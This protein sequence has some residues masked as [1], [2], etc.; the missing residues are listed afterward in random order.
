ML[1][2]GKA[3][4]TMYIDCKDRRTAARRAP[5]AAIIVKVEGGYLAFESR[6]DY[7]TWLKQK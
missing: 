3:M 4:R 2:G 5:W 6:D 7:H 1:T